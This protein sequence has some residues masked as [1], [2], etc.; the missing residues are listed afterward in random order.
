M[1]KTIFT[2]TA[3]AMA[4]AASAAMA[5]HHEGKDKEAMHAEH[6]AKMEAKIAEKFAAADTDGSGTIS[7]GEFI[8]AKMAAAEK[9]W[10]DG[11]E[12]MGDDGEASLEEVMARHHARMEKKK[13][14]HKAMKEKKDGE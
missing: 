14:K 9:E 13:A 11:A 7:K 2:L 10:A 4:L 3:G 1:K 12:Y 5:G 8:A 6:K